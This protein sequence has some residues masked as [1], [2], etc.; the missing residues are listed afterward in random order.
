[1]FYDAADTSSILSSFPSF[2]KPLFG[3]EE[4]VYIPQMYTNYTLIF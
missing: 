4:L 1:M 3:E 2:P